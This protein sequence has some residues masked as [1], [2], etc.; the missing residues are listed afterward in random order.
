METMLTMN[1]KISYLNQILTI[2]YACDMTDSVTQS[3]YSNFCC[4][5]F[6]TAKLNITWNIAAFTKIRKFH[7][8]N[9]NLKSLPFEDNYFSNSFWEIHLSDNNYYGNLR[10]SLRLNSKNLEIIV[11]KT[12]LSISTIMN[13]TTI[14]HF[15]NICSFSNVANNICEFTERFGLKGHKSTLDNDYLTIFLKMEHILNENENYFKPS[16]IT[17]VTMT[18]DMSNFLNNSEIQRKFK[19]FSDCTIICGDKKLNVNKFLLIL[20]SPVFEAMFFNKNTSE[21]KE[22]CITISDSSI[23]EVENMVNFLYNFELPENLSV[24]DVTKLLKLAE[25]YDIKELKFKC[26]EI[27]MDEISNDNVCDF[28]ELADTY[29]SKILKER[30]IKKIKQSFL[31][32]SNDEKF[33]HLRKN[34]PK[35]INEVYEF[36]FLK[37]KSH[38]IE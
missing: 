17:S 1:K 11:T 5:Y 22:N 37:N 38:K 13:N 6:D 34:S 4:T 30:C 21:S 3:A 29:H 2:F 19:K 31:I 9:L 28:L 20:H 26:E 8:D 15:D 36:I 14:K 7:L 12:K 32:V 24:E 25:K 18:K 10:L 16:N 23:E 27:L 33:L 35:L